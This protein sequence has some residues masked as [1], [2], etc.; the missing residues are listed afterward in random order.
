MEVSLPAYRLSVLLNQTWPNGAVDRAALVLLIL[1][2]A[3]SN[4]GPHKAILTDF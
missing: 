2:V 4:P 3:G 1:E